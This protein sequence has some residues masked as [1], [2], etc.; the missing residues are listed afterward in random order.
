MSKGVG[1]AA[2]KGMREEIEREVAREPIPL[3]QVPQQGDQ[4]EAEY[5][6]RVVK[7]WL[8]SFPELREAITEHMATELQAKVTPLIE[9]TMEEVVDKAFEMPTIDEAFE[10]LKVACAKFPE[11]KRRIQLWLVDQPTEGV[12][13]QLAKEMGEF[14]R[15]ELGAT[16]SDV[17]EAIARDKEAQAMDQAKRLSR[18]CDEHG[19]N[20]ELV[21]RS[22]YP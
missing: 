8:G 21:L 10:G 15:D 9:S 12:V 6:L 5:R 18:F 7:S 17:D 4:A 16:A 22:I 14:A 13:G 1:P 20:L 3:E 2:F 19:I 11:F